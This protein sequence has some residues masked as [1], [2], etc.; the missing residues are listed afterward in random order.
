MA[1]SVT[2]K[3]TF[4][5]VTMTHFQITVDDVL[6]MQVVDGFHNLHEVLLGLG[7]GQGLVLHHRVKVAA[8]EH[9]HDD[10][11]VLVVLGALRRT[12]TSAVH[13]CTQQAR[14]LRTRKL[15]SRIAEKRTP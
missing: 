2:T 6:A 14:A 13:A 3:E 11:H 8:V 4:A 12:H 7:F 1:V 10:V 9:L 5:K 15:R